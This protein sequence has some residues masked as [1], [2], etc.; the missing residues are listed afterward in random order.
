LAVVVQSSSFYVLLSVWYEVVIDCKGD[1]ED[2]VVCPIRV[3]HF[4][5]PC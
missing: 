4:K 5:A 3:Q 2:D 1:T